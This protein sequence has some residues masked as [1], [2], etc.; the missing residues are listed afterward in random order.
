MQGEIWRQ[1]PVPACLPPTHLTLHLPCMQL[2]S[3]N[4]RRTRKVQFTCQRCGET[5]TR[6][7]NPK[8]FA[9]GTVFAQCAGCQIIHK[10]TDHLNLVHEL[11]GPVFPSIPA[12]FKMPPG[13]P[14]KPSMTHHT[15]PAIWQLEDPTDRE[16]ER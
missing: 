9:S 15:H 8:A 5:T 16:S 10:L 12:D 2:K 4:P 11:G 7:I 6:P 3:K 1:N 14:A 13:L